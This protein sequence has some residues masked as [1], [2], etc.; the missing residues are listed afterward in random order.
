MLDHEKLA[1]ALPGNQILTDE[2]AISEHSYDA[3]PVAVKWRQQGK[4]PCRPD[5]V[6]KPGSTEEVSSLVA[7]CSDARI[8][9]TA[10]GLGSS[11]VGSPLTEQGGLVIDLSGM[12]QVVNVDEDNMMVTVQAGKRGDILEAELNAQGYTLNHSPQSLDR[13]TVGGWVATRATGQLSSLYGGMEDM[14]V[15]IKVVLAD[16]QIVQTKMTPRAAIGLDTKDVFV[17]SEGTLG[18]VTEVTTSIFP[19][20]PYKRHETVVFDDVASGVATMR[21]ITRNG[22]KPHLVR[23]YDVDEARHAMKDKSFE[24]CVMFLGFE[25]IEQIVD[26]EYDVVLGICDKH[27]GQ[28]IGPEGVEGWLGRRYDFS[29]VENIS[30]KDGRCTLSEN[31]AVAGSCDPCG[32]MTLT[33]M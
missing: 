11:V 28:P 22:L 32:R 4:Q 16:G 2:K 13:S 15:A 17:G 31:R 1:Q 7:A 23:F 10:W 8:A 9:I 29:A 19:L 27:G 24:K 6:A 26:A 25:G 3:W 12:D 14:L 21:E 20:K 5:A 33:S 30:W 18:I